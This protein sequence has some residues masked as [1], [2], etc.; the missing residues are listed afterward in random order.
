MS[1]TGSVHQAQGRGRN[2][3]I[4]HTPKTVSKLCIH[5][6]CN[7]TRT[8]TLYIHV[9]NMYMYMCTLCTAESIKI[10]HQGKKCIYTVSVIGAGYIWSYTQYRGKFGKFYVSSGNVHTSDCGST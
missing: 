4:S 10:P 6:T 5:I 3:S 2:E 8:C 1:V 7:Y 9:R